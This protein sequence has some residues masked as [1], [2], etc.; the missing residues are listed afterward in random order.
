MKK[1]FGGLWL[2]M[3]LALAACTMPEAN[4]A[5]LELNEH[6]EFGGVLLGMS[7]EQM[8]EKIGEAD[9]ENL[10]AGGTEY[11]YLDPDISALA[12]DDGVIRRLS[13]KN[14][15]FKVFDIAVGDEVSAADKILTDLGYSIDAAGSHRYNK[16]EV[17]LILLT[18]DGQTVLGFTLEWLS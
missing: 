4:D 17:Q 2:I 6:T 8:T 15:A 7:K 9:A 12:D 14:A 1:L 13:S 3:L 18:V 10:S 16:N 5:L 11:S